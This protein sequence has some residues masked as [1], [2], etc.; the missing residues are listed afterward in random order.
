MRKAFSFYRS[1]YEQMKLLDKTQVAN[2]TLAICEVQFLEVNIDDIFFDDK[3]TQ[4]VWTGIKHG[5]DASVKGYTNKKGN[6]STPLARGSE[7]VST[8][9]EQ[10]EGEGEGEEKEEGEGERKSNQPLSF[11]HYMDVLDYL[12]GNDWKNKSI[13]VSF[14]GIIVKV[15]THGKA[16]NKKTTHD[17]D[18]QQETRFLTY[19]MRNPKEIK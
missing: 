4:L 12:K 16:Y 1:H 17:L 11:N 18:R 6:V 15:S 9:L 10:G 8:P 19:L 5:V 7:N 13:E 2:I 3:M 14:E